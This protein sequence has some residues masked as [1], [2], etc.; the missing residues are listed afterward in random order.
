[1][2]AHA[3]PALTH[4]WRRAMAEEFERMYASTPPWDIGR[5]QPALAE[6]A[7]RGE[8][9]GRVLDAGCGTGE[10]ALMAARLG[11]DVTGIDVAPAAIAMAERKAHDR[12]LSVRFRVGS[13]LELGSLGQQFDTVI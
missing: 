9:R 4:N 8:V 11:L 3:L 5:A 6:L 7:E 12:G 2:F 13:A 10:Q 1:M